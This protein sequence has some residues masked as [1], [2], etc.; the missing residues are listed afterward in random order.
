MTSQLCNASCFERIATSNANP[1]LKQ[2]LVVGQHLE[3]SSPSQEEQ[4]TDIARQRA[5]IL[6][7]IKSFCFGAFVSLLLQAVTFSAFWVFTIYWGKN[8]QS[9]SFLPYW[10][11]YLLM[12]M[13]I[14]LCSILWGG[15]AMSLTQKGSMYMRKKFDNDADAPN[16][17]SVWTPRFLLLSGNFVLLGVT[18]CRILCR[19]GYRRYRVGHARPD[20]VFFITREY[21]VLLP[22]DQLRWLA[23][24]RTLHCRRGWARRG[25]RRLL[26][27]LNEFYHNEWL[28]SAIAGRH[29]RRACSSILVLIF[30]YWAFHIYVIFSRGV[31]LLLT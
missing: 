14:A 16:S 22:H 17:E 19:M 24:S 10:T 23:L 28:R 8:P 6:I 4:N 3:P 18:A 20:G 26:L 13:G 9:A 11:I 7:L 1:D 5:S 29:A 27:C 30:C 12:H 31:F 25:S 2:P 21:G 15:C